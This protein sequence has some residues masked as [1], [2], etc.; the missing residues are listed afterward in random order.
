[1]RDA[2]WPSEATIIILTDLVRHDDNL[3]VIFD[4]II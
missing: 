4:H 2:I 3:D 1:M